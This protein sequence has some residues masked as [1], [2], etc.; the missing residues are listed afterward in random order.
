VNLDNVDLEFFAE[1]A[2]K[3]LAELVDLL[4][5]LPTTTPTL[6][7]CTVISMRFAERSIS[8]RATPAPSK[9]FM[10][11]RRSLRSSCNWS[12]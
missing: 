4:A 12:V 9:R 5:P 1:A 8:T 7:V 2:L 3:N 6:A 10:T 11:K